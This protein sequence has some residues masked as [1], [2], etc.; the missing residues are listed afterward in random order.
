APYTAKG[1]T[2]PGSKPDSTEDSVLSADSTVDRGLS[3]DSTVDRGLNGIGF[4]TWNPLV[5]RSKPYH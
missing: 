1:A 5:A 4:R 2:P 3:A